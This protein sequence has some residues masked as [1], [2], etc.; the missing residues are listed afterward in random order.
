M[1]SALVIARRELVAYFLSPIAYLVLTLF[2]L[3]QGYSFWLF[4][5]LLAG[6]DAPHGAV[7]QYFFG[8]TFLY[9]LFVM[10]L[11]ATITMRLVAEERRA[12]TLEPLLTAPVD[13]AAVVVGKYLGALA[14]WAALWAPTL[15]YVLVLRGYAPDAP[16]AGPIAAGYLGTL[17]VGASA[18]AVGTLCST[19]TRNQI[20]AAVAC[21]VALV[22]LL[23]VGALGDALVRTG[24][25]SAVL[26]YINL[27][28]HMEDFGRGIVDTRH[29]VYHVALAALALFAA[30]IAER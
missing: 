28:R 24:P 5:E 7:M 22:L 4:I 25:W 1:T 21:F 14:F 16:D 10:F 13:E 2:L 9:W 30:R 19:V 11:V 8:G 18:L 23:L 26:A 15:L 29:V 27:F 3:V 17:L 6:R 12:G 20:V